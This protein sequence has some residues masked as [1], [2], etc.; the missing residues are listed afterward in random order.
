[1]REGKNFMHSA[2]NG[3]ENRRQS[4]RQFQ[5]WRRHRRTIKRNAGKQDWACAHLKSS[6]N[7]CEY[8]SNR[9]GR[10]TRFAGGSDNS[11][12]NFQNYPQVIL[13][14]NK[15]IHE[16][17][18]QEEKTDGNKSDTGNENTEMK[19]EISIRTSLS[20][21]AA[22]IGSSIMA[23]TWPGFETFESE[24]TNSQGLLYYRHIITFKRDSTGFTWAESPSDSIAL[25]N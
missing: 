6:K 3:V 16:P 15:A 14:R 9:N 10:L 22:L 25:I 19:I 12:S 8:S 11:P 23:A 18:S 20:I 5:Y 4:E 24:S 21:G 13:V 2:G 1:M 17:C 7:F